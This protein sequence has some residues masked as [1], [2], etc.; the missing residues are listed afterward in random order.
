MNHRTLAKI[1]V[2]GK[3]DTSIRK[4]QKHSYRRRLKRLKDI[5]EECPFEK[6]FFPFGGFHLL[7]AMVQVG[8]EN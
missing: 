6:I 8:F 1:V 2:L 5:V 7:L 3:I 4:F